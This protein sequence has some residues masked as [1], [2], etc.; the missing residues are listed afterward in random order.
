MHP[1]LMASAMAGC[2]LHSK[3]LSVWLLHWVF[4]K[5][6]SVWTRSQRCVL[7]SAARSAEL[8]KAPSEVSIMLR[9]IAVMLHYHCDAAFHSSCTITAN[10]VRCPLAPL[11][12]QLLMRTADEKEPDISSHASGPSTTGARVSSSFAAVTAAAV[13]EASILSHNG[14]SPPP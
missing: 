7:A 14:S 10:F 2:K 5:E 8:P 3:A 13:P 12:S 9:I 6:C 11:G 1:V 4:G